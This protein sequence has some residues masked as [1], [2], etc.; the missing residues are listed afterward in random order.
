MT[1]M[2][3]RLSLRCFDV[4]GSEGDV[5]ISLSLYWLG[6]EIFVLSDV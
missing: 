5:S 3:A 2:N 4:A 1:S 6:V